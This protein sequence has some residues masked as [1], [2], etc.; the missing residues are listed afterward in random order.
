MSEVHVPDGVADAPPESVNGAAA[1]DAQQG[2]AITTGDVQ[3]SLTDCAPSAQ[4][5]PITAATTSTPGAD[6]VSPTPAS[7]ATGSDDADAD[8][9]TAATYVVDAAADAMGETAADSAADG[10]ADAVA[11]A[12]NEQSAD[13]EAVAL[14]ERPSANVLRHRG[15]KKRLVNGADVSVREY[16]R[17]ISE[18]NC[19]YDALAASDAAQRALTSDTSACEGQGR[20]QRFLV[21]ASSVKKLLGPSGA[22]LRSIRERAAGVTLSLTGG[23]SKG[24]ADLA[25]RPL[26]L[27]GGDEGAIAAA[28]ADV[29][30]TIGAEALM[31][32]ECM[33]P[34][35]PA[36]DKGRVR[37]VGKRP[38]P[39]SSKSAKKAKRLKK[40]NH[41]KSE[42]AKERKSE[43]APASL[44][45]RAS[46]ATA[47]SKV[48]AEK[49]AAEKVADE[50][51]Q[52]STPPPSRQQQAQQTQQKERHDKKT[53]RG[54]K[55]GKGK[56]AVPDSNRP[57]EGASPSASEAV[58]APAPAPAPS[59]APAAPIVPFGGGHTDKAAS[60]GCS[61]SA[62]GKQ[63]GPPPAQK[64]RARGF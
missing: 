8:A 6:G 51:A 60:Q 17:L 38:A 23:R 9:A 36:G 58:S 53:R 30:S 56:K 57:Q 42:S 64:K 26:L 18:Y 10:A 61:G 24:V 31:C 3:E 41:G 37:S 34:A 2:E 45:E 35:K 39:S 54:L 48:A 19:L 1:T 11:D 20:S 14:P 59:P 40:D 22:T 47:A 32:A 27:S 63:P 44:P 46:D 29:S 43:S 16:N 52:E 33:R 49:V 5:P 21:A 15:K 28:A 13:T 50:R 62:L 4:A 7:P 55:R 12:T 25:P